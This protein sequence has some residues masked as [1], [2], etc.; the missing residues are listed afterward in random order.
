MTAAPRVW[1]DTPHPRLRPVLAAMIGAG[2][3]LAGLGV[4][5]DVAGFWASLPFLTNL[6][7]SLT[8]ALFGIP[9]GIVVVQR[10]LQAQ[11]DANDRA[12]AW[13][14]ALRSA[15]HM[16]TAA[17]A[18]TGPAGTGEEL[19]RLLARC[20]SAVAEAREW[21]ELAHHARPRP[22]RLRASMYQRTYLRQVLELHDAARQALAVYTRTSHAAA[23]AIERIRSEAGFLHDQVRPMVLRLDGAWLPP[24]QARALEHL[25]E[26]FPA[27]LPRAAAAQARAVELLLDAMAAPQLAALLPED[28]AA[29][30]GLGDPKLPLPMPPMEQLTKVRAELGRLIAQLDRARRAG[31]LAGEIQ[32]AVDDSCRSMPRATVG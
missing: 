28:D 4:A 14:L 5:G 12:A 24:P 15:H 1:F 8:G 3:L 9:V 22:R 17:G 18:L 7:S 27:D 13:R 16:R 26:S 29:R 30:A 6:V 25:D 32:D 31:A 10:L 2:V 23:T 19:A 20:D 21:A 11:T